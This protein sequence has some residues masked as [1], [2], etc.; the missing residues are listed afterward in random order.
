MIFGDFQI[1]QQGNTMIALQMASKIFLFWGVI[2]YPTYCW[3]E[4][5]PNIKIITA[6]KV[7]CLYFFVCIYCIL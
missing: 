6:E 1:Q 2:L 4:I 7:N 5:K 3:E